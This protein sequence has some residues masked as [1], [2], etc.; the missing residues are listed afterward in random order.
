M[1]NTTRTATVGV[2]GDGYRTVSAYLIKPAYD[3]PD[4][5]E[6]ALQQWAHDE[7]AGGLDPDEELNPAGT[8]EY[9]P[10]EKV[11]RFECSDPY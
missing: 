6:A 1:N 11:V 7:Y 2:R 4:E 8:M 10:N 5:Y 9:I 3:L